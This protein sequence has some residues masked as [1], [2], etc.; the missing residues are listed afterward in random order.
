MSASPTPEHDTE[1]INEKQLVLRSDFNLR[2][3]RRPEPSLE[4][5]T[6]TCNT[7]APSGSTT[8]AWAPDADPRAAEEHKNV[9]FLI[10]ILTYN[11]YNT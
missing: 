5:A 9:F 10:F 11:L 8:S 3:A 4:G 1:G 6:S 7:L 2:R